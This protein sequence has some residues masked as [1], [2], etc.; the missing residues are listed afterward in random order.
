[1][2]LTIINVETIILALSLINVFII[3]VMVTR[4]KWAI[5]FLLALLQALIVGGFAILK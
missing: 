1:M 2:A 3:A 5:G 4:K